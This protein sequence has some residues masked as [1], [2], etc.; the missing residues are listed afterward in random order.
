LVGAVRRNPETARATD[1]EIENEIK[2]WLKFSKDRDG[3][4]RQRYQRM[5]QNAAS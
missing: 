2:A 5:L 3:G 4:R 1:S